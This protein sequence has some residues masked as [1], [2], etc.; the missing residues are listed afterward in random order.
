MKLSIK[1]NFKIL[2]NA[3]QTDMIKQ[4]EEEM[5]Q[6]HFIFVNIQKGKIDTVYN[7]GM[8][9]Q[10]ANTPAKEIQVLMNTLLT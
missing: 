3:P 5:F 8:C 7:K 4:C 2:F 9:S 10:V 1:E 6:V